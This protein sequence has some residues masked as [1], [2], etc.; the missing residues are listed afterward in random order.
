M[1]AAISWSWW[2]IL[3]PPPLSPRPPSQ[4]QF[5]LCLWNLGKVREDRPS[6]RLPGVARIATTSR[7]GTGEPGAAACWQPQ[8]PAA[9]S[10]GKPPRPAVSSCSASLKWE[11]RPRTGP[12]AGGPFPT[13]RARP[14]L[15][16][17]FSLLACV[18]SHRP[19]FGR[20]AFESWFPGLLIRGPWEF[21]QPLCASFP[22]SVKQRC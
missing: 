9:C 16:I 15:R 1:P 3:S 10:L 5:P 7:G 2:L 14:R 21:V 17:T 6:G 11:A 4:G 20:D 12:P 18:A 19:A 13:W 22:S 8:P